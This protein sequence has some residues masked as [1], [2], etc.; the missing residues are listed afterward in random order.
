[1]RRNLRSAVA[2][3][4]ARRRW[5]EAAESRV[6]CRCR[7]PALGLRLE[8]GVVDPLGERL[9]RGSERPQALG[10]R[11]VGIHAIDRS[12]RELDPA[13]LRELR[14]LPNHLFAAGAEAQ[15]VL[16]LVGRQKDCIARDLLGQ[17]F[18]L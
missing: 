5:G 16:A 1:W 17:R 13:A 18:D 3:Y 15:E 4:A 14:Q 11:E 8:D 12:T 7:P 10:E 9:A 6:E 2:P